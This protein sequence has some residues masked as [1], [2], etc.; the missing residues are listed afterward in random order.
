MSDTIRLSAFADEISADPT[1]QVE[2]LW[3]HGIRFIEFRSIFGTN[4]LDLEPERHEAFRALLK[5]S[6]MGLSAIGSPIGKIP[7]TDPMEPHLARLAHAIDLAQSYDTPNIRVFS[8]Y[9]PKG[10]PPEAYRDEVFVRMA[11]MAQVAQER[12]VRLVLENE[13]GIYGDTAARVNEILEAVPSPALGLAFDPANYLEVGQEIEPAWE[14]LKPRVVHFHVK[15]YDRKLHRNVPAGEGEGQIPRL[16]ADAV[17]TGYRGFCV[18]EPHLV[19]AEQSYGFTG[20]DRFGDAAR[21][22]QAGLQREGVA[23]A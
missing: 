21:A 23:Y 1:E 19:V 13:K 8:F 12:G 11:A 22:L 4:V 14:L 10:E 3:R 9:M 2:V 5:S 20:P 18:L 15:D 6:G 17:R 16:I 7:I